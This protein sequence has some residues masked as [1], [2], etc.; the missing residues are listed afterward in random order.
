MNSLTKV[1][2]KMFAKLFKGELSLGATFWKFGILG[3]IILHYALKMFDSLLSSYLKG[4]TM[5][6][7]FLNEFHFIYTS[8][9][10][11][12]WSLCYIATFIILAVYSFKIVVAIWRCTSS[13]TKSIWL[14]RLSRIG[15]LLAVFM[16]WHP[17]FAR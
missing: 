13:Y 17:F 14:V 3:L 8:K 7:F 15:I 6:Y 16:T 9:L 5:L 10:S 11:L 2:N 1:R 4:K 12:L